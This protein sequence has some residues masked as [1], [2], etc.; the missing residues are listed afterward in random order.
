M[1]NFLQMEIRNESAKDTRTTAY[2][3]G[4]VYGKDINYNVRI[5]HKQ[6]EEIIN[7]YVYNTLFSIKIDNKDMKVKFMELQR[8]PINNKILHFDLRVMN[9]VKKLTV[10]IPVV[11]SGSL[12]SNAKMYAPYYSVQVRCNGDFIPKEIVCDV[13]TIANGGKITTQD[14][15]IDGV[16]FLRKQN[17]VEVKLK[18]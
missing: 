9:D 18:K 10:D 13:E 1:E 17:L 16:Q 6:L 15:H 7:K 14:I 8:H 4:V 5:H 11:I 12:P 3:P 2:I